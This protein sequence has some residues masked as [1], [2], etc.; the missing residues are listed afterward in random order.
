MDTQINT[1]GT[2]LGGLA[3]MY[4]LMAH[5]AAAATAAARD[6]AAQLTAQNALINQ[7]NQTVEDY[8]NK[9]IAIEVALAQLGPGALRAEEALEKVFVAVVKALHGLGVTTEQ[10]AL[11]LNRSVAEIEAALEKA[12]DEGVKDPLIALQRDVRMLAVGV[13]QQII[14]GIVQG[15]KDFGDF[16]KR[17][18]ISF[19]SALVSRALTAAIMAASPS[20]LSRHYGQMVTLGFALGIQDDA[21]S[22]TAK[23]A[24]DVRMA[25]DR[26]FDPANFFKRFGGV[27]GAALDIAKAVPAGLTL[28]HTQMTP[29]FTAS[30][31]GIADQISPA[32]GSFVIRAD[33]SDMP[34]PLTPEAQA[35]N[36]NWQRTVT[37]TLD[38]INKRGG[39]G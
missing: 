26:A 39:R 25:V 4:Q 32:G 14:M 18:I 5:A 6:N 13:G 15:V 9:V 3:A 11:M 2:T 38:E 19:M 21:I 36:A 24:K 22:L 17:I 10:I 8:R 27:G 29:A 31:P 30:S 35:V 16:L 34:Q 23:A 7:I 28:A 37:K 12:T 33:F 20:R 1:S